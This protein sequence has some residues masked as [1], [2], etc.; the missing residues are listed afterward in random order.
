MNLRIKQCYFSLW[1]YF[2]GSQSAGAGGGRF[3]EMWLSLFD[4]VSLHLFQIFRKMKERKIF[5]FPTLN[6]TPFQSH[7][8]C[9][10]EPHD[11]RFESQ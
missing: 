4:T 9:T 3:K 6:I 1:K 2:W 11:T 8:I 10:W 5:L 7:P